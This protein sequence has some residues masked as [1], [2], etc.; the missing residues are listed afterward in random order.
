MLATAAR[1]LL[2]AIVLLLAVI[3][4]PFIYQEPAAESAA[5]WS[6]RVLQTPDDIEVGE[7]VLIEVV[8]LRNG[9]PGQISN[10]TPVLTVLDENGM[11][12]D[13]A[14]PLLVVSEA[15]RGENTPRK[16]RW[17]AEYTA[18]R[19]GAAQIHASVAGTPSLPGE[20]GSVVHAEGMSETIALKTPQAA[21]GF[22]SRGT[23]FYFGGAFALCLLSWLLY[24]RQAAAQQM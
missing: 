6:L 19:P 22:F 4:S 18:V 14:N 21:P 15:V 13:G 11:P 3:V 16:Q 7:T 9:L 17:V 1:V 24:R 2:S 10:P 12:Q 8:L 5:V 20:N 23:S